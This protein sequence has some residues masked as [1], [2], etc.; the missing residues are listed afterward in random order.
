MSGN[1]LSAK[2][3]SWPA[4]LAGF[5]CAQLNHHIV[6]V[7]PS[8]VVFDCILIMRNLRTHTSNLSYGRS[9]GGQKHT[10]GFAETP[11]AASQTHKTHIQSFQ[12][13]HH[14]VSTTIAGVW[15]GVNSF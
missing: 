3:L 6:C 15:H 9:F 11:E 2:S 14:N 10:R 7:S 8:H 13:D 5:Q 4:A 1:W 12:N